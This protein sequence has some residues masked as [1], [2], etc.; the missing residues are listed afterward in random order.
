MD[1]KKNSLN[2][3]LSFNQELISFDFDDLN[4]EELEHRLELSLAVAVKGG[5]CGSYG[6]CV[7]YC[8]SN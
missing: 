1:D 4:A 2:E 6:G 8:W 5:C 3:L 7:N